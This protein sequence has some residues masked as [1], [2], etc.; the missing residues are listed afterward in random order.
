MKKI[1]IAIIGFGTVGSGVV[2][3]LQDRVV[4]LTQRSGVSIRIKYVCDVDLKSK[5]PVKLK[6]AI[7]IKDVYEA[8][9]D[10]DVDIVVELIG[11]IHPAKEFIIAA[12]KKGKHVVTANK[13]L[14]AEYGEEIFKIAQ[15]RGVDIYFEASVVAGVPIIKSLREGFAGDKIVAVLGIV[16]GTCNFILS[17]MT[18]GCVSF[19][20]ALKDAQS[21]GYA[22]RNPSLDIKGDD[23][24]HK[25]VLLTLL[26]FGEFVKLNDVYAEGI[27]DISANDIAYAKDFGYVIKL[28]AIAKRSAGK[29]EVRVAPTLLPKEHLLANVWGVYNAVLVMADLAGGILFNGKG[30]GSMAAASAVVSDIVDI[31]RNINSGA[32]RRLPEYYKVESSMKL[33]KI[34]EIDSRYYIRFS[35]IDK[36]GVLAKISGVL[37]KYN[38]SIASVAQKERN[39][40][41]VVPVVI[42]THEAK[43]RALRAA[44]KKIDKLPIIKSKSVAIRV[45]K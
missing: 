23:S 18:N 1:N 10:P 12:M 24:A 9:N 11:G 41:K 34:S 6:N 29:L 40:S 20:D 21:Q 30:A 44:L 28:L 25:L 37:G 27:T 39:L 8:I 42:M 36:P 17:R 32:V 22:E 45:E 33:R 15:A 13:A 5:R 4:L 26:S 19:G 7:L 2:K 43:E 16:N 35:A 38:I 31:A 14:L 3:I